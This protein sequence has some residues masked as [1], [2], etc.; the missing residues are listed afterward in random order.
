MKDAFI[1]ILLCLVILLT[2]ALSKA[3]EQTEKIVLDN[4]T[5]IN[6]LNNTIDSLAIELNKAHQINSLQN[7]TIEN[8]SDYISL[9]IDKRTLKINYFDTDLLTQNK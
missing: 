1:S 2:F 3:N 8:L 6:D 9:H 5:K 7:E 4:T